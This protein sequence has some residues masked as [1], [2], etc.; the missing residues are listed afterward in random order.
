[1]DVAESFWGSLTRICIQLEVAD[2]LQQAIGDGGAYCG[3]GSLN[4]LAGTT[5]C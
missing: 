3:E 5:G 2:A 4:A 1:M